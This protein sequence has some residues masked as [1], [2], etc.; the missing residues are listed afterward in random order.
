MEYYVAYHSINEKL[1]ELAI[2]CADYI[3]GQGYNAYPQTGTATKEYGI[4]RTVMPHSY[5]FV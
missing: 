2:M 1:D 4:F 5:N 3:K